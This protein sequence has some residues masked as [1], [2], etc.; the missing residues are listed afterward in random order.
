MLK[1]Q[2]A[3]ASFVEF[4]QRF[5]VHLNAVGAEGRSAAGWRAPSLLV[6]RIVD[7]KSAR[8]RRLIAT[9][10][11][12]SAQTARTPSSRLGSPWPWSRCLRPIAAFERESSSEAAVATRPRS[13]SDPRGQRAES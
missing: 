6:A 4:V 9:M 7:K 2:D 1:V 8:M 3:V 11:T 5:G 12:V 13:C 10:T